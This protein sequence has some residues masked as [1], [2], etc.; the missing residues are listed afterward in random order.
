MDSGPTPRPTNY[1][2]SKPSLRTLDRL[3]Q[4]PVALDQI[5]LPESWNI[6]AERMKTL[7]SVAGGK[8]YKHGLCSEIPIICK[9]ERCVYSDSCELLLGGQAVP[10]K[11]CIKEI[12]LIVNLI[13]RYSTE[14]GIDTTDPDQVIDAILL[15]DLITCEVTLD[16]CDRYLAK[17][18]LIEDVAVGV[19]KQGDVVYT[20]SESRAILIRNKVFKDKCEILSLLQGTRKDKAKAA[21]GARIKTPAEQMADLIEAED[22]LQ[23]ANRAAPVTPTTYTVEEGS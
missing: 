20:P 6:D 13:H 22:A 17:N 2:V 15:K 21:E 11:R 18:A 5:Q 14:L 9:A 1:V 16:R 7:V 3:K 8:Q 19:D 12:G 4:L 10:G 23:R